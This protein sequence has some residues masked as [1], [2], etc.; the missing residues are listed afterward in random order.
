LRVESLLL[1]NMKGLCNTLIAD[2]FTKD[3]NG[4][5]SFPAFTTRVDATHFEQGIKDFALLWGGDHLQ[6]IFRKFY[7]LNDLSD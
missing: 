1:P 6:E 5:V 3:K 2:S 7:E 4:D